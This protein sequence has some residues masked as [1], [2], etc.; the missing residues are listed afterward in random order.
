MGKMKTQ[1]IKL[2]FVIATLSLIAKVNSDAVCTES[3][4]DTELIQDI[5]DNN[6]LDC[7]R[8]PLSPPTDRVESDDEKRKRLEGA[9]DTDCAFEA[10]YDWLEPLKEK[11]G[12][13]T[14]LVDRDGKPVDNDFDDQAD[15]CEIVRARLDDLS[16]AVVDGIDCPGESDEGQSEICAVSGGSAAQQ[17]AWYILLEGISITASEKPKWDLEPSSK[18]KLE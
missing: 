1:I 12:L 3:T 6:K 15:M 11:Y 4:L 16:D 8:V 2:L 5:K 10:D 17:Y 14:G 7:L 13:K 9:W 18:K